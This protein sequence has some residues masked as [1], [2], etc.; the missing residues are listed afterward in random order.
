VDDAFAGERRVRPAGDIGDFIV[1]TRHGQPAYQLAVVVDDHRQGVTQVV[2]GDDL[3]SSAGRQLLLYRA[4]SLVPEPTYTHLP[5]VRGADGR[6][7]AKRHGDTRL[8]TYRAAGIDPRRVVR[9]LAHWCGL[10][11]TPPLLSAAEFRDRLDLR[12]IPREPVMFTPEDDAWLK[13]RSDRPPP[14]RR[15]RG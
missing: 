9:L 12:T 7:L 4:L 11:G 10:T 13:D 1:W 8:D 2:R 15:A 14:S 6:R 5:L 3:I